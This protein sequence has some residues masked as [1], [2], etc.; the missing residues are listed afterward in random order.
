MLPS[1]FQWDEAKREANLAK[2]GIDFP[3]VASMFLGPVLEASD[4][5]KDYGEA[6]RIALGSV[7]GIV[8]VVVYTWRGQARRL[9]SARKASSREAAAFR[10]RT[11]A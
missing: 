5:R 11:R 7:G 6:R 3:F 9:I 4:D 8:I 10:I 1:G 2:H